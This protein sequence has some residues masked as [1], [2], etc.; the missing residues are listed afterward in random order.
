MY[1]ILSSF[2]SLACCSVSTALVFSLAGWENPLNIVSSLKKVA[3]VYS[4]R[5]KVVP[6]G[7]VDTAVDSSYLS[8]SNIFAIGIG[9]NGFEAR[10]RIDGSKVIGFA[11]A[12]LYFLFIYY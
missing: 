6:D 7:S 3:F 8:V 5:P 12:S 11:T 10:T 2:P 4:A 1:H 9:A